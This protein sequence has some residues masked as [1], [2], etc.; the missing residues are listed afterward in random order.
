MLQKGG[1]DKLWVNLV[2]EQAY[3]LFYMYNWIRFC[4]KESSEH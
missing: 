2:I 4:R 3:I 1:W